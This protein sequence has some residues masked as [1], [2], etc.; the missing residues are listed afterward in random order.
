MI[1]TELFK[2][3]QNI[4]IRTKYLVNDVLAGEYES[5]FKGR[6]MEFEEVREYQPGDDIR[7]IDWNVTA[8][9]GH[10]F[11]KVY[12][13]ERELTVMLLVDVSSSGKFGSFKKLKNEVS[14]EIAAILAFSAVHNNDKVGL[15]I[16]SDTVEKFIPPKKGN[17]HVWL[18]IKEVLSHEA[19]HKGT[20]INQALEF[21]YRVISRRAVCFFISDFLTTGF[22]KTFKIVSKKHDLIPISIIDPRE[23]DIPAVGIIEFEDA[24]KGEV[25][26][27]NTNDKNVRMGIKRAWN[28]K[29]KERE[30]LFKLSG[31]D[32][33]TIHTERPY[34][35][36]IFRFFKRREKRL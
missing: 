18:V 12:H 27:I 20:D 2:Q 9:M 3:I 25:V 23:M 10:P 6:G 4:H 15:I 16:F 33:I 30:D 21:L 1:S 8:R 34:V 26:Y 24:E 7:L 32:H 22:E 5:T 28:K 11:V 36:P 29:I 17:N 31:V 35:E 13:E 19:M 14:A